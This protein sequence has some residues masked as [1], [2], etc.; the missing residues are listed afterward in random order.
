MTDR[1]EKLL[2]F[3][4]EDP[5]DAF[6]RFSLAQEYQKKGDTERALSFYEGLAEDQPGYVGTY[7]HLGKL[8]E[9]LGRTEDAIRTY[10]QGV[11]VA[12]ETR[13][14][15]DLSELQDALMQAQGIGF[16]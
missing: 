11:G 7:Y 12:R 6:T 16:D 5:D 10:E 9:R 4:E 13:A 2:A 3:H 14:Q 15:K 8:Y 1:I